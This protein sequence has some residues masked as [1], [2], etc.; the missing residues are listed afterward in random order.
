MIQYYFYQVVLV[1]NLDQVSEVKH[2]VPTFSQVQEAHQVALYQEV[3][4]ALAPYYQ[5]LVLDQTALEMLKGRTVV[6]LVPSYQVVSRLLLLAH[7]LV[8]LQ[9]VAA[10]AYHQQTVHLI[11]QQEDHPQKNHRRRHLLVYCQEMVHFCH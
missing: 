11:H 10:L 6:V 4:V 7:L 2:L 9:R 3:V 8:L 5:H 1:V